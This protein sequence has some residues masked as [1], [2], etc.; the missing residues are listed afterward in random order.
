MLDVFVLMSA[1]NMQNWLIFYSIVFQFI[2]YDF[3]F[4]YYEKAL[5]VLEL[6]H[7]EEEYTIKRGKD[8]GPDQEK[9]EIGMLY[10]N[11]KLGRHKYV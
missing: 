6:L 3:K 4:S 1:T 11:C 5:L 2:I 8:K 7:L 10:E 9:G